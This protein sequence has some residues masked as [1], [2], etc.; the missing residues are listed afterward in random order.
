M[1][2]KAVNHGGRGVKK[3]Q[4]S[5]NVVCE[6]PHTTTFDVKK[7]GN[8]SQIDCSKRNFISPKK[9]RKIK[10]K[11]L[12][13]KII[14]GWRGHYLADIHISLHVFLRNRLVSM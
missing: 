1:L 10:K 4:K 8:S 14:N 11:L 6:R 3:G 7:L 9:G 13:E 5:V 2:S 12:T